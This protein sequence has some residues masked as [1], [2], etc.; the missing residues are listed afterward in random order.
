[1]DNDNVVSDAMNLTVEQF[2]ALE[3]EGAGHEFGPV[4]RHR[5]ALLVER[6]ACGPEGKC[7][8]RRLPRAVA[9]T[10]AAACMALPAGA[11]AVA[12]HADFLNGAFGVGWRESRPAVQ[13]MQDHGGEKPST[14]VV[15][16]ASEAVPVDPEEA[17]HILGDAV[18]DEPV[19]IAFPDGHELAIT[20]AVRSETAMAY[21]FT[22]HRDGGVTCLEWDERTNNVASKGARVPFDAQASWSTAGDEF[23][24][25]DSDAS[26]DD[27]LV[28]YAYSVFGEPIAQ[29]QPVPLT[30]Y[31]C[32]V[33]FDED[34]E[35]D[36][37]HERTIGIPCTKVVASR[38]LANESGGTVAVSP[39][40]L[41]LDM[42]TLFVKPSNPD[43]YDMATGPFNVKAITIQMED[44]KTYAV[45]DRSADL[46]NTL[47]LC[48]F[49]TRLS[50]AFNRLIDPVRV[51]S[52][53]VVATGAEDM[54]GLLGADGDWLPEADWPTRIVTYR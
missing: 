6:I 9:A 43:G 4:Y 47:S 24:Y 29:G 46:D 41:D 50:M 37:F 51:E 21:R 2:D 27:A 5:K 30:I 16:P 14:P 18:C 45:F 38:A 48:G 8:R 33:P 19:N 11:Y 49:D 7:V 52:V 36:Q 40:G 42:R 39:L 35:E 20:S 17:G 22:L 28:G 26:T 53:E 34:H 54:D 32:D 44:G 23:I 1:M 13:S 10:L 3:V 25:V 15:Y 12:T 31:T